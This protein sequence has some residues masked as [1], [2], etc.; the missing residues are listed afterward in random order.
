MKRNHLLT[1]STSLLLLISTATATGFAQTSSDMI[2]RIGMQYQISKNQSWGLNRP[3]IIT[4]EPGTPAA[5]AGLMSG[6]I[7]EKINDMPTDRMSEAQ[8]NKLIKTQSDNILLQVSNFS[9]KNKP[10]ILK[11]SCKSRYVFNENDLASAFAFYSLEDECERK[12]VYPFYTTFDPNFSLEKIHTFAFAASK[13]RTTAA[14]DKDIYNIIAEDLTKMG[15][16]EDSFNPDVV[17]DCFYSMTKNKEHNSDYSSEVPKNTFRYSFD[18]HKMVSTPFLPVGAPKMAANYMLT[19]GIRILDAKNTD[20]LLWQSEAEELLSK[21]MS[22]PQ[23]AKLSIPMMLMQFPFVRYKVNPVY[24]IAQHRHYYTGINY[25]ISDPSVVASV[26][27]NSPAYEAGI[28]EN[29]HILSINGQE[30][31]QN[32]ASNLSEDYKKF[33]DA[34]LKYRDPLTSFTDARGVE[35]CRYWDSRYYNKIAKLFSATNKYV[36]P[37]AY[38]FGFRPY[39]NKDHITS[40]VFEVN[41]RDGKRSIIVPP[42]LV[43]NSYVTLY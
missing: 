27:H 8:I 41:N 11:R 39:V 16:K 43:E 40:I 22:I 17:I 37:F 18:E 42:V 19:L 20:L 7:I 5:Q 38:I 29:D 9:R 12:L 28:R 14:I 3:V 24:L 10:V 30:L 6:D 1:I 35:R 23:Y 26:D 34:T 25:N 36:T 4:V 21:A 2:C 31:K 13:D 32:T 33:I 15:L